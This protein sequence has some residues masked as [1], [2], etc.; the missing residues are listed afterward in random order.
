MEEQLEKN[1]DTIKMVERA[2]AVLDLLRTNNKRLGVNEVAKM[3]GFSP[4]TTFRI[5]KTLQAGGWVYQCVDDS[6]IIGPKISFVLNNDRLY[7]VLGELALF[8]MRRYTAQYGHAMNL[9]VRDGARCYILQQSRTQNLVDYVPPIYSQLPFYA[10][11]SGKVLLSE[12]NIGIADEIIK[13]IDMVPMT[14]RTITDPETFWQAIREAAK[15]GFAIDDR[16]SSENGSCIAVPVRSVEGTVIAAL[17]F[18]GLIGVK[19]PS[20]LVEYYPILKKAAAEISASLFK[21][22]KK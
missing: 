20:T 15:Q 6:Y 13:S 16:E 2:L 3:C 21:C 5:L 12:L 11:A 17:S 22:W 7:I 1:I 4:S 10:C 18:S 14:S 19:D 8:V 9:A